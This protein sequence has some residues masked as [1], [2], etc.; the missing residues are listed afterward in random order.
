MVGDI[1]EY[2]TRTFV[3]G[4]EIALAHLFNTANEDLAGFVPRTP[5]YWNWCCLSRPDVD[6]KSIV[7]VNKGEKIVGYAVVG[8][9]GNIWE[10]CYDSLYDGKIIVSKL[11][12]WTL[13]YARSVG[14]DSMVLNAFVKDRV[15]REVCQELDFA[16]TPPELVFF[17][18]LDFPS[19]ICEILRSRKMMLNIDGV[20]WFKLKGCP[21]WCNDSFGLNLG[22]NDVSV[23]KETV[24][25]PEV[26]VEADMSILVAYIFGTESIL[27]AI[28]ASKVHFRPFWKILK[29]LK[30]F[31]LLRINSPWF[32]PRADIG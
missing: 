13:D 27:K 8:K 25:N 12:T 31:S 32:V 30:F 18:V 14:T 20:F 29:L 21:P 15:V 19:L 28:V 11:L 5:K 17:S 26:I 4:D 2:S 16:E 23:L 24:D 3:L 6:E 22:K 7:I 1:N 9:S 10:L